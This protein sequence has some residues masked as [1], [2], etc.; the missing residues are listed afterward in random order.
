MFNFVDPKILLT[1]VKNEIEK[2]LNNKVFNY[3]IIYEVARDK[4]TFIVEK[5]DVYNYDNKTVVQT[6]KT[7]IEKKVKLTDE[8]KHFK[9]EYILDKDNPSKVDV[10]LTV[11]TEKDNIKQIDKYE[12]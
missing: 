12:L 6:I 7:L 10:S 4:L 1:I 3:A 11:Y 5:K 2:Q 8:L 9:I